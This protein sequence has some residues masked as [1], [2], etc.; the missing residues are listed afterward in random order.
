MFKRLSALLLASALAFPALGQTIR[1]TQIRGVTS[2]TNTG[3]GGLVLGTSPSI[4]SPTLTGTVAGTP[5]WASNQ[6][7]TLSTAAQPNVTSVGTLTGLTSAYGVFSQSTASGYQLTVTDTRTQAAGQGPQILFQSAYNGTTL[8]NA[9]LITSYKVNG[10]AGNNAAGLRL[11]TQP[12][13][14]ALTTAI[15][16]SDTQAVTLSGSL[17]T[18]APICTTSIRWAPAPC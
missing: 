11:L 5:T 15:D 6:A 14:G 3:T 12:N 18:G 17:S 8:S 10:T 16:I 4:A 9:A 2:D 7:I 1:P 13:G